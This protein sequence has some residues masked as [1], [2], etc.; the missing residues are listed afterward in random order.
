M[1]L[2]TNRSIFWCPEKTGNA[3]R[4]GHETSTE[5]N[6]SRT[7]RCQESMAGGVTFPNQAFQ[8]TFSPHHKAPFNVSVSA[9][10]APN[11]LVFGWHSSL[12]SAWKR[13]QALY[14]GLRLGQIFLAAQAALCPRGR[15][16]HF[17]I[18]ETNFQQS[19]LLKYGYRMPLQAKAEKHSFLK[20]TL[21]RLEFRY[22][23]SSKIK[24][25][26]HLNGMT[27]TVKTSSRMVLWCEVNC[28]FFR[29]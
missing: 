26:S 21:C 6:S 16:L 25:C 29:C 27:N 11:V 4:P 28:N 17:W 22:N 10:T 12:L 24:C 20:I 3:S 14:T 8:G 1:R 19:E 9:G 23:R 7:A 2:S 15:N 18:V 13:F 5:T